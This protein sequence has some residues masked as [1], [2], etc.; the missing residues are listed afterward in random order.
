MF[1]FS[2]LAFA[3]VHIRGPNK[4]FYFLQVITFPFFAIKKTLVSA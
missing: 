1:I 4:Y 3:D 2:L